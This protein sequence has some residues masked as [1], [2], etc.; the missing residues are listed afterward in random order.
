MTAERLTQTQVRL[1]F[2]PEAEELL[3]P[4]RKYAL[5]RLFEL[6]CEELGSSLLAADVEAYDDFGETDPPILLL[7]L[8]A[9]IKVSEWSRVNKAILKTAREEVKSW[10]EADRKDWSRMISFFLWPLAI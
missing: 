6:A 2:D 8:F 4:L 7:Q 10:P 3:T 9:D 1:Q 5:E